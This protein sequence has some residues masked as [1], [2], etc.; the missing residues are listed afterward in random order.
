MK[1]FIAQKY[2]VYCATADEARQFWSICQEY[3]LAISLR[4]TFDFDVKRG[5]F[6]P[7]TWICNFQGE[8]ERV[9]SFWSGDETDYARPH[10]SF[11]KFLERIE[12]PA[13]K[14]SILD[15]M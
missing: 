15:L 9:V 4:G 14:S 1:D 13:E 12:P 10:L 11:S 8:G 3:D 6:M 2:Y 7:S 5:F